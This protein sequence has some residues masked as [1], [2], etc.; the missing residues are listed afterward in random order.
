M[1][2]YLK[3]VAIHLKSAMQYKT[4]FFLTSLSQLLLTVTEFIALS[5]MFL[6]FHNIEGFT[7]QECLL[8]FALM[9]LSFTLAECVARGFDTFS[10]MI[11]NGEFDRVLVRPRNEIFQ[12][13]GSKVE[14]T[15]FGRALFALVILFY[16]IGQIEVPWN[17]LRVLTVILMVL[18][19]AAVFSA[20]FLIYAGFC[21]FTIEGLE[22]MNVFTDGAKEHGQYPF[23]VYGKRVLRFCTYVVP[24]ALFQVYPLLY[25]I[26]RHNDPRVMLLPV[27]ACW[28]LLPAYAFWRFGVRKYKSTGS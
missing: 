23:S 6:R 14:F 16:A 21:F 4:S 3:Y 25:V 2:L 10:S 27:L 1:K 7:Y 13:L 17:A 18:G 12:V 20:L 9:K 26:G 15:R 11:S 19:G 22:F 24:Y 28:F 5:F 8:C